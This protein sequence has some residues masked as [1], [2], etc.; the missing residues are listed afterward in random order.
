MANFIT[1]S[2]SWAG[3]ETLDY[4]I[5]PMFLGTSPLATYG[6]DIKT[7]VKDKELLNYFNP[8][9]KMTK[10]ASPGFTGATGAT[11]SQRTLNVYK[12]KAEM[13]TDG[14]VFFNTV[15]GQIQTPGNWNDLS[16]SEQ[17]KLLMNILTE[18]F[19]EG[20]RSDIFRQFWLNDT[21][22]SVVTSGVDTGVADTNYN[23]YQ[24]M[25][26]KLM[27]NCATSPSA[28]QIKRIAVSDGAV[29]Q[30]QTLAES[31]DASGTANI[32][33]DGVN[34]LATRNT[35]ATQTFTDFK[36]T[37]GA[38]L[39]LK[40]YTLSGTS[41]LI[42]TANNVGRPFAAVTVTSVSGT[43]MATVAATTAN[44]APAALAAGEAHATLL[45][46]WNGAPA[47]LKAIDK[48]QKAFYVG[49]LVYQNMM[50]YLESTG[51]TI[52]GYTNLM[53]GFNNLQYRGIP[54]ILVGWDYHL[55]ADF[56]HVAGSLWAYPHRIIYSA[57]NNL[58]L[59]IDGTNE[60]NSFD[61]WFNKDLEMN[62]WR[63]KIIM[64][65]EYKHPKLI[66][67]AY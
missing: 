64:G 37:H 10:A 65:P 19:I 48:K 60:F 63:A 11:Y 35:N 21:N 58:F 9:A 54:V 41:T 55:D 49:D 5:T 51:W 28:T 45:A 20:F 14:T 39:T 25:W 46:L 56:A 15:F 32:L 22:K 26:P 40:G 53:D 13:E 43:W 34:Y 47:E 1:T 61:F 3:K 4:L 2:V 42:I 29:A 44:T 50:E 12:M 36:A 52:P 23:A 38:A 66:A 59:G 16:S 18:L 17:S 30:V 6:I 24:G 62:R 67:I 27:A 7:Q 31:V 8:V 33:I 57:M